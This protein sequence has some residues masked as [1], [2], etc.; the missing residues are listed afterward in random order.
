MENAVYQVKV[1]ILGFEDIQQVEL[2]QIDDV[3]AQIHDTSGNGT[4]FTLVNPY[5]LRSY[6]F[7]I[8]QATQVLLEINSETN[9]LL[10]NI[11]VVQ[12]P[13]SES[14]V[15]FIAPLLFNTDN[16][17]MSQLILDSSKHPEYGIAEPISSF[18]N[19]QE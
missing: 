5:A 14:T 13:I 2:S 6:Q 7:D 16:H 1:P 11:V 17:T 12:N 3:F 19:S 8:P 4:S 9:L 10:Y 15:N 18:M